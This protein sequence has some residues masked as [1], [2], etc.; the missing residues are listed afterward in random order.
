MAIIKD[1]SE[2][3]EVGGD[4]RCYFKVINE[5]FSVIVIEKGFLK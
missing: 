2:S 5:L 3:E 1:F 4:T